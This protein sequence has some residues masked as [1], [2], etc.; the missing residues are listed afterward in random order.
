[1]KKYIVLQLETKC[2]VLKMCKNAVQIRIAKILIW[3]R[4][5]LKY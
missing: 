5:A 1:M 2:A 3:K 4:V